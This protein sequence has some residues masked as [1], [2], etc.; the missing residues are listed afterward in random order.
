MTTV[1]MR[2]VLLMELVENMLG[3]MVNVWRRLFFQG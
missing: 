3:N 2:L 1:Y